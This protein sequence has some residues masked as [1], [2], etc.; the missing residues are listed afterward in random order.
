MATKVSIIDMA[1]AEILLG[2]NK[3]LAIESQKNKLRQSEQ[4]NPKYIA[5]QISKLDVDRFIT[6]DEVF[7]DIDRKIISTMDAAKKLLPQE[8]TDWAQRL[9]KSQSATQDM[10]NTDYT[11]WFNLYKAASDSGDLTTKAELKRLIDLQIGETKQ[12]LHWAQLILDCMNPA[13]LDY[14]RLQ[15]EERS[16]RA[17]W[18]MLQGMLRDTLT[19]MESKWI[20]YFE[21]IQHNSD[22]KSELAG[23]MAGT[24]LN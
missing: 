6:V 20:A 10:A 15:N 14:I 24:G 12:G 13:E 23:V 7:S 22:K 11:G 19:P 1:K 16:L 18:I 8:S 2:A 4:Y 17:V 9:Y 21:Q 3:L 5:E